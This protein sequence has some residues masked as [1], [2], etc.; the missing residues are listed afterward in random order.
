LRLAVAT[1]SLLALGL[2]ACGELPNPTT[3][4]DLRVIGVKCEPAGFLVDLQNIYNAQNPE[5][6]I[7]DYRCRGSVPIRGVPFYPIL[8]IRG[9][10]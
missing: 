6:T 4:K 3:V 2:A 7:Y 10:F 8:G 9:M 1:V 5:G